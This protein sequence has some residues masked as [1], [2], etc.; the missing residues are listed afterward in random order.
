ME[1]FEVEW[2][3]GERCRVEIDPAHVAH[4]LYYRARNSKTGKATAINGGVVITRMEPKKPATKFS[5]Q[6]L[7]APSVRNGGAK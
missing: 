4:T 1:A 5:V 3:N 2:T 6:R 7:N